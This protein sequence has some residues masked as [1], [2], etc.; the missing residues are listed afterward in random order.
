MAVAVGHEI[1]QEQLPDC[2]IAGFDS[3]ALAPCF[4]HIEL[5]EGQIAA[6]LAPPTPAAGRE[7]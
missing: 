1:R 5:S 7:A 6:A 3:P 2:N 4:S